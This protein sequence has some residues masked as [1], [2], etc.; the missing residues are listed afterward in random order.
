MKKILIMLCSV[1]LF[2]SCTSK[3]SENSVIQ[4]TTEEMTETVTKNQTESETVSYVTEISDNIKL[5]DLTQAENKEYLQY[6]D[7]FSYGKEYEMADHGKIIEE[8]GNIYLENVSGERTALIK[9][10][11][12]SET[13][14]VVVSCII[15]SSRFAY[16][17]IQ[18]DLSLGCG[19]YNLAN[20]D[21]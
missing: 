8:K 7:Q 9:L 13:V 5:Y 11:V 1:F 10:P 12:E 18:E 20:G 17:I 3:N 15:D 2:A 14:Y 4:V 16:N 6:P 19:I 21:D